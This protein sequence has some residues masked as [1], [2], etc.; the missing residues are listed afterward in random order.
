MPAKDVEA[1][2]RWAYERTTAD[3]RDR[4]R[5][6]VEVAPR[7]LTV[8]ECSFMG[9]RDHWLRVPSARLGWN[10]RRRE[11]TLYC[12]RSERPVRYEFCEPSARVQDLLDEIEADPTFIFWG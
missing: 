10:G 3:F 5:V 11:W 7:S 4:M 1:V 2:Q 12:F 8:V 9:Y 6:E